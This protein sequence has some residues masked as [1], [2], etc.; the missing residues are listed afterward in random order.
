MGIEGTLVHTDAEV[1]LIRSRRGDPKLLSALVT[2]Y[3]GADIVINL[4]R[5]VCVSV[6]EVYVGTIE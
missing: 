6:C 3:S 2:K 5:C 4:S 1:L